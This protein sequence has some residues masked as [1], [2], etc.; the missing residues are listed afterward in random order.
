MKKWFVFLFLI[1]SFILFAKEKDYKMYLS[2]SGIEGPIKTGNYKGW[3][4]IN[5]AS[6]FK[7]IPSIEDII[8]DPSLK[9]DQT[10]EKKKKPYNVFLVKKGH[11]KQDDFT[12]LSKSREVLKSL[13][14]EYVNNKNE[15]IMCVELDKPYISALRPIGMNDRLVIKCE[16]V[17]ISY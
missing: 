7:N 4:E 3:F 15:K 6:N 17:K 8:K 16:S 2:V 1:S 5:Y 10:L 12:E 13:K 14:V 9:K 11:E